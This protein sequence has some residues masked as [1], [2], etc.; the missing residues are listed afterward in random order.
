MEGDGEILTLSLSQ[1]SCRVV[2]CSKDEATDE[3]EA[4][5]IPL[6]RLGDCMETTIEAVGGCDRPENYTTQ[7]VEDLPDTT[8]SPFFGTRSAIVFNEAAVV[9]EA[10]ETAFEDFPA[11]TLQSSELFH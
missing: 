7:E 3:A 5:W 10:A 1:V 9:E 8:L 6:S 11:S 2:D 4:G